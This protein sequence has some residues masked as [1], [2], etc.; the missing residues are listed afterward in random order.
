ML[1]VVM[2]RVAGMA[3]VLFRLGR[4]SYLH[5]KTVIVAWVLLLAIIGGLAGAFQK[6]FTDQF[7]IEDAPSTEASDLMLE[8]FDGAVDPMTDMTVNLVFAAPE[9]RTLEEPEYTEAVEDVVSYVRDNVDGMGNDEQLQNPVTFAPIM[10]DAII[11]AGTSSG[12]SPEVAEQDAHALRVLSDDG[13]YGTAMFSFDAVVQTEIAPDDRQAVFD[14]MD[15]GREAGLE[16]EANGPGFMDP[17]EIGALSEIIGIFVAFVVLVI[18]F[19]S[20]V[21]AGLPLLSALLGVGIGALGIVFMTAFSELN[22]VTPILAVM[23]GLAVG[24]DYA[25][26]IMARYRADLRDG[27][28]KPDAAGLAVATA[29][30]AVVFAGLT[31]L[32]ALAALVLAGIPFLSMM[33]ISAAITVGMAVVISLTLVPALFGVFG[34]RL[35]KGAV[36]GVAGNPIKGRPRPLRNGKTM[37]RRWVELVHKA[38]GTCLVV[39]IL[40]LGALSLPITGMKLAIPSDATAEYDSTQRQATELIAEGFGEGRNAPMIVVAVADDVNPDAPALAPLADAIQAMDPDLSREEAAR[41][42]SFSYLLDQV[43]NNVDVEH[44]QIIGLNEAGTAAQMILTPKA[45]ALDGSTTQLIDAVRTQQSQIEASTGLVTGVTG[46]V[47]IELDVTDQLSEAMPIYLTVVVG[48]AIVLLLLVFRSLVVPLT[49]G[50]G[51]LLSVGAAFGL[52]ILFWQEG[53]WGIVPTP[54]PLI[55]FMPIF[56]IGVTFGLAMDYQVFLVSRMREYYTHSK[57]KAKPGSKYTAV[58]ESI[59]EGFSLGARVVTAAAIIMITVFVAFIGQPLPFIK[60]FGFALGAAI[61]FDAFFIRM[62]FIPAAMFLLG[63]SVWWLPK[64]LD[65]ILPK[66]DV[67]GEGI[68][69]HRQE[70]LAKVNAGSVSDADA[71]TIDGPTTENSGRHRK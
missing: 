68:E 25:L 6:G 23:I 38:P 56:L 44:I 8:N 71:G 12:M 27:I 53:L 39:V 2:E 41:T 59:I 52:T 48:L 42:A 3:K 40:A 22:S 62:T 29:G 26:F 69:E 67:E 35:F 70:L 61:L 57:G 43:K 54:G 20:L 17:V 47:P 13:R 34:D 31:V 63:R 10:R 58:D 36:P 21:S 19:G 14:A 18:T 28:D 51:F 7:V 1:T 5:K 66:V 33:G 9:G 46:L 4:W 30:S 24:I 64:W 49:A 50:I 60:I 55:S 15:I 11:E 45:G 16:V 65:K 32:I 37:G